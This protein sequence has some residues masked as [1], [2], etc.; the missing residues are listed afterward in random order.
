MSPAPNRLVRVD[1]VGD[2]IVDGDL[3]AKRS[4]RNFHAEMRQNKALADSL[5]HGPLSASTAA[6]LDLSYKQRLANTDTKKPTNKSANAYTDS[7]TL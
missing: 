3:S 6:K 4:P 2:E 7:L 1:S 5:M